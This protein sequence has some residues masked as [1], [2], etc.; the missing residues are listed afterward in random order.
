ME[1]ADEN[2]PRHQAMFAV[3]ALMALIAGAPLARGASMVGRTRSAR[4]S[5]CALQSSNRGRRGPS[6]HLAEP[7]C[8]RQR[9]KSCRRDPLMS[10]VSIESRYEE[11]RIDHSKVVSLLLSRGADVNA[12]DKVGQTALMKALTGHASEWK[13]IGA[14]TPIVR[15]LLAHGA[16][17][18]A[19]DQE[20][21]T[22]LVILLSN[23][24]TQAELV[25]LLLSKG[26]D[27]N[28]RTKD[29]TTALMLAAEGAKLEV[30]PMLLA[31]GADI[32]AKDNRG[33]TAIDES[34]KG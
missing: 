23:W 4:A 26:A 17:V 32:N 27:V 22:P 24:D 20:G 34:G 5:R 25:Q 15:L 28:A 12:T 18:N 19:K 31:K 16:K 21:R 30:I 13:V 29:A 8:R 3:A 14:T 33:Q 6:P 11:G 1:N 2:Y 10:A 7:G 9:Q